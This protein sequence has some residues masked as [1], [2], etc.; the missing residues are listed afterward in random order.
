MLKIHT[1]SMISLLNL[2]ITIVNSDKEQLKGTF[3]YVKLNDRNKTIANWK[4]QN[5]NEIYQNSKTN[6]EQNKQ[7]S[8]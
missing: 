4:V 1:Q 6:T 5:S 8:N 7:E 3:S 2:I